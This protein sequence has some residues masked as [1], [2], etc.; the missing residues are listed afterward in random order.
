VNSTLSLTQKT[1]N[2]TKW[3]GLISIVE[4]LSGYL[5][6]IVLA[7]LL[8]PSDFALMAIITVFIGFARMFQDV[9]FGPS[10]V[11]K[12]DISDEFVNSV[13][14]LT[15]G[16]GL[17]F[18]LIFSFSASFIS[19]FYNNE[20]LFYLTIF[21]SFNFLISPYTM[22]QNRLLE[23]SLRLKYISIVSIII[24]T[25]SGILGIILAL[26][27]FG[28]WSIAISGMAGQ[29][30][31][32][33][34]VFRFNKWKPKFQYSYKT[35]KSSTGFALNLSAAKAI[36]YLTLN[37]PR[38]I[39]GKIIGLTPLG[40]YTMGNRI[41]VQPIIRLSAYVSKPLLASYSKVQDDNERL[42]RGYLKTIEFFVF[43]LFPA[44]IGIVIIAPEI[45]H[46]LLGEKWLGSIPII[47]M[48]CIFG[49][50]KVLVN[51]NMSVF[52]AINRADIILK[53]S[54]IS[55][56][57]HIPVLIFSSFYGINIAI[58]SV[59]LLYILFFIIIQTWLNIVINLSWREYTIKIIKPFLC[60]IVM[61]VITYLVRSIIIDID[62]GNLFK[63][64]ILIFTG[65]SIY[66]VL[67]ILFNKSSLYEKW[68][69][70]FSKV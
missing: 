24:V 7:R 49:F 30:L 18:F 39:F 28:V 59:I 47:Q 27:G 65:I 67:T 64:F 12:S 37:L 2:A 40:L 13:F 3:Y 41:G 66:L 32:P 62:L 20:S 61:G 10:I 6:T 5:I 8:I 23:R 38:L 44:S 33:I 45:V 15:Q 68:N 4:Q 52:Y 29:L 26:K 42:I 69:M 25:F 54:I 48:L 43:M 57:I 58:A 35:L 17:I 31:K 51:T 34:I 56:L 11:T 16:M 21:V 55:I 70:I 53:W 46:V 50:L 14:W 1:V 63:L 60:V 19:D 9:G 36:G 22:V